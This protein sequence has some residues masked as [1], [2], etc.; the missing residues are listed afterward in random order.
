MC[1]IDRVINR[2]NSLIE[3]LYYTG[4]DIPK[5]EYYNK[6]QKVERMLQYLREELKVS[7]IANDRKDKIETLLYIW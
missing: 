5:N 2:C 1:K 4:S 3:E 6:S 7:S